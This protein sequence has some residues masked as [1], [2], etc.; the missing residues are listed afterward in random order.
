MT[1]EPTT[2]AWEEEFDNEFDGMKRAELVMDG[3]DTVAWERACLKSFIRILLEKALREQETRVR[4]E[5]WK[6]MASRIDSHGF[7]GYL[8]GEYELKQV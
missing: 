7:I 5:A 3:G 4:V 1:D 2:E 6:L 8:K